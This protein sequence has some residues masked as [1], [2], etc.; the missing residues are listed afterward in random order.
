MASRSAQVRTPAD[1]GITCVPAS[2]SMADYIY[3]YI[4]IYI[5]RDQSLEGLRRSKIVVE[6]LAARPIHKVRIWKCRVR[7]EQTLIFEG[8]FPPVQSEALKFLDL[9]ILTTRILVT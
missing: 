8:E 6:E 5:P 4:Y 2:T 9:G 3:I 7:P 1:P